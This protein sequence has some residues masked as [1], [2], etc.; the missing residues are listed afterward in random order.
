MIVLLITALL[1]GEPVSA[2][3]SPW[4]DWQRFA[5]RS[6]GFGDTAYLYDAA[7]KRRVGDV[8]SVWVTYHLH[9]SGRDPT[10]HVELW[11]TDCHQMRGRAR[12]GIVLDGARFS[13]PH[14][15]RRRFEPIAPASAQAALAERVC[16]QG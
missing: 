13:G 11:E 7:S 15:R 3:P 14:F 9:F 10:T 8:V 6:N 12:S 4:S 16:H 2:E 5:I 1:L